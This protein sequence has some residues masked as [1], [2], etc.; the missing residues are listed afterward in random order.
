MINEKKTKI[1]C[2]DDISKIENYEAAL[3]D[4]AR[5]WHVHHRKED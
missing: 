2:R 4:E 1:Y 3:A 5:T